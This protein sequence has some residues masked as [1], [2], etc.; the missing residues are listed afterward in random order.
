MNCINLF[1][2]TQ[3]GFM[4]TVILLLWAQLLTTDSLA[5]QSSA[6]QTA[7]Q[8][9][10]TTVKTDDKLRQEFLQLENTMMSAFQRGDKA[11]LESIIGE[12]YILVSATSKGE[13]I[14]KRQYIDG[15][16]DQ[17]K[18]E[19]FR[20]HDLSVRLIGEVAMVTCRLEWKS[21]WGK[22]RWDADFLMT[23]VWARRKGQWQIVSRHSSYP[24]T[25]QPGRP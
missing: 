4:A 12:E 21:T 17:I 6:P 18:V 13:L 23:D 8:G 20:F 3:H 22:D 25:T 2:R 24:A 14:N 5:Q 9:L 16:T 7:S 10:P 15:G 19:H 1:R 11:I